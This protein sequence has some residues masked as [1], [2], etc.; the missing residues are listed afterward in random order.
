MEFQAGNSLGQKA[1]AVLSNKICIVFNTFGFSINFMKTLMQV[2]SGILGIAL[3]AATVFAG[4]TETKTQA[5]KAAAVRPAQR[6]IYVDVTGSRI[7]QRVV[8]DGRQVNSAS[9]LTVYS[10]GAISNSGATTVTSV[11]AFDP[12]ITVKGATGR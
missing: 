2:G 12:D 6:V 11:L 5:K 8:V 3:T 10:G 4:Q 7:P 9:P 1:V